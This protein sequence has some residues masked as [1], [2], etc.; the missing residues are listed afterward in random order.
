TQRAIQ[1]AVRLLAI[2]ASQEIVHRALM[3]L[4]ALQGRRAAALKQYQA[5]VA[6]L[7]RELGTEPELETKQLYQEI[8]QRRAPQPPTPAPPRAGSRT[9]VASRSTRVAFGADRAR[10]AADRPGSRAGATARGARQGITRRWASRRHHRGGWDRQE[11]RA[12][13]ARR[14]SARARDSNPS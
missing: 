12:H 8:L 6:A 11:Q 4:Y 9:R 13:G 3:R 7:Q 5:C 10:R 2:D 14:R 1:T